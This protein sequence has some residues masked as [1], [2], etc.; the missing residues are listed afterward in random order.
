MNFLRIPVLLHPGSLWLKSL[1]L[2][3]SSALGFAWQYN[4]WFA[5]VPG[6]SHSGAVKRFLVSKEGLVRH[7]A[8]GRQHLLSGKSA[9]RRIRLRR[10]RFLSGAD[11]RRVLRLLG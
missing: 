9:K 3:R 10:P 4:R 5:G 1:C 7:T 8:S 2:Y 6:K 11:A